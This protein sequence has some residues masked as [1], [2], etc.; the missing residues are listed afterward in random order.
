MI[1]EQ[2][3]VLPDMPGWNRLAA[4]SEKLRQAAPPHRLEATNAGA[5]VG[6][7]LQVVATV[8]DE[9]GL[10]ALVSVAVRGNGARA[11]DDQ[12][13]LVRSAWG[14]EKAEEL[15]VPSTARARY[16]RLGL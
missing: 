6:F 3:E 4:V 13:G 9:G 16:L 7:G 2:F 1:T 12:M 14:M 10:H 5:W 11:S 8:G 15:E